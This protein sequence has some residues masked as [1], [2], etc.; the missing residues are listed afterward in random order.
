MPIYIMGRLGA[1]LV[2]HEEETQAQNK[3]VVGLLFSLMIYP[4]TF[5]LLWALFSYSTTGAVLAAA[6]VWMFAVYHTKMI[7]GQSFFDNSRL[8]NSF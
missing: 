4:L 1:Q 7:N 8:Q 5:W 2:E 3:V 6:T